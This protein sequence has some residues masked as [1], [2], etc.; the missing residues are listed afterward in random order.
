MTQPLPAFAD[1]L[2][3]EDLDVVARCLGASVTDFAEG[4]PVQQ[5]SSGVPF[6]FV[7]L[8]SRA[9]VDRAEP[10]LAAIRAADPALG[11]GCAF[12]FSPEPGTPKATIYSRMFAPAL[13]VSEDPATGSATGPVG[14]YLVRHGVVPRERWGRMLSL[15]GVAMGRPSEVHVAIEASAGREAPE[16]TRVR[17]GGRAVLVAR[18][19][20]EV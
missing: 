1:P 18:G 20:I 9:A 2:A 13:G 16:I 17:V 14:A 3:G 5:V 10:D 11:V 19:T 12:V 8:G 6:L 4:L 15:Q 7:P